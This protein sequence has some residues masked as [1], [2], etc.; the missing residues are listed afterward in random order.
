VRAMTTVVPCPEIPADPA[1]CVAH[2]DAAFA[3]AL[4][5]PASFQRPDELRSLPADAAV[6]GWR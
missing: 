5:D 3:A 6:L 1:A 2:C 4:E